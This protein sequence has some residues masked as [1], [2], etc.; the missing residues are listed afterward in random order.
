M[1]PGTR[2]TVEHLT[3]ELGAIRE[4]CRISEICPSPALQAHAKELN[5]RR[6]AL[7]LELGRRRRQNLQ[8]RIMRAVQER[9][10]D[11]QCTR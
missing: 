9:R 10:M 4:L 8:K 5:D 2:E 1:H 6:E 7:E 3:Y 11:E